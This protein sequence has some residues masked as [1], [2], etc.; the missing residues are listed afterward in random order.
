[1]RRLVSF[2]SRRQPVVSRTVFYGR[3][4]RNALYSLGF[5]SVSLFAGACGYIYFENMRL[6]DAFANASM[7]LASMG[8][9]TP[10]MTDGG[11]IFASLYAIFSGLLLIGISSLMLAPVFHRILHRFHVDEHDTDPPRR[12]R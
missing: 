6:V 5:V 11:K 12:K 3:L 4:A 9:L 7:I 10:L 1:M 2:E 8:P